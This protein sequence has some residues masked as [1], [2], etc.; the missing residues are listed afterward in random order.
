[1][2]DIE[3]NIRRSE[4]MQEMIGKTPSWIVRTGSLLMFI[5]I[6]LLFGLSLWIRY[7]EILE[8][9]INITTTAPPA[10]LVAKASGR[11]NLLVANDEQVKRDQIIG[12]IKNPASFDEVI[13]LN[14]SVKLFQRIM[15]DP[16]IIPSCSD[17]IPN[18]TNL[19][20]IQNAYN[21]FISNIYKY[22]LT[23]ALDKNKVLVSNNLEQ[24]TTLEKKEELLKEKEKILEQELAMMQ[25]NFKKDQ[26][27]FEKDLIARSDYNLSQANYLQAR[28]NIQ[29]NRQIIIENEQNLQH[30]RYSVSELSMNDTEQKKSLNIDIR[31]SYNILISELK[32]YKEEFFLT[33]P[34]AGSVTFFEYWNNNQ[35]VRTGERVAYVVVDSQNILGKLIVKSNK[36]GKVKIGQKV[37][38]KLSSYPMSE[39]G[40]LL[41]KVSNISKV[42]RDNAYSVDVEL[43]HN[44]ITTYKRKIPYSN[45]MKGIGEIVTEDMNLLQRIF[46]NLR[47]VGRREF[48]EEEKIKTPPL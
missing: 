23:Y 41:G 20:K 9:T 25:D 37:R 44:L 4:G 48:A 31:N 34:I 2:T 27:L 30:L 11:I 8:G 1:M 3:D 33:S 5:W 26:L 46:Y 7:P 21:N 47:S 17:S 12:Y 24:V 35:Y 19:G 29:N 22:Q 38:I 16:A 39:Y 28:R 36:F 10:E 14:G 6:I 32:A 45:E 42:N 13:K 40:I 43:N 15:I 18:L